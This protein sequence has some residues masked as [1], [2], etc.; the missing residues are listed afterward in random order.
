MASVTVLCRA[1]VRQEALRRALFD[2]AAA[3]RIT[4]ELVAASAMCHGT[5]ASA[6]AATAAANEG[7][8]DP[9]QWT[10][11]SKVRLKVMNALISLLFNH[12]MCT[13]QYMWRPVSTHVSCYDA[14]VLLEHAY[15]C[16][17]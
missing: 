1:V 13:L 7:R 15:V 6:A 12:V 5:A 8:Q 3:L 9:V 11:L 2:D 4:L 10:P 17:C 14:Q 16:L